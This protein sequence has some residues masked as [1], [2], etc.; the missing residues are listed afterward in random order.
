M[1]LRN[2][3]A[4]TLLVGCATTTRLNYDQPDGP[5]YA[6]RPSAARV[7]AR[8]QGDTLRLVS[9]NIEFAY[10]VDSAIA[11]L[12]SDSSLRGADVVLLQE[13]DA[14]G[15]QR[16]ADA[17]GM[18]Y[19]YYPATLHPRTKRDMG[20]AVLSRWPIVADKKLRLPHISRFRRTQ[21]TATV[22]TIRVAETD[23]RVY[24]AHLGTPADIG[25]GAR[26]DQ[27][28]TILA[29]AAGYRHVII[30]GDM[31][32]GAVGGIAQERGY[33]WPTRKGHRTMILGR[34]DHIFLKGLATPDRA[35]A[36]TVLK[37]RSA[38]DHR[39]IWV[40]AILHPKR[41]PATQEPGFD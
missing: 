29:D 31:N 33:A 1:Q 15:T 21:R 32:S 38:S 7:P 5:R 41:E 36:G 37:V 34:W 25:P 22:A 10:Q 3:L 16:I 2:F 14:A 17:L 23:V 6:G 27:L 11:V 13:M 4:L 12:T 24:S 35:A 26:R 20:N 28:R 8:A 9:F 40:D 39:P 19:A 30:G 18:W